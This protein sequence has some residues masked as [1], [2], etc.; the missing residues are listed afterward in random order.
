MTLVHPTAGVDDEAESEASSDKDAIR[1]SLVEDG[2]LPGPRKGPE[3]T[4]C[5][6]TTLTSLYFF[7]ICGTEKI[8]I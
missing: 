1:L 4:I 7:H 2:Y 5:S 3:S 8:F 6:W